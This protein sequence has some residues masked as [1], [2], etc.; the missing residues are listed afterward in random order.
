MKPTEKQWNWN[1]YR[2]YEKWCIVIGLA[3]YVPAI[4]A[5][6]VGV[7]ESFEVLQPACNPFLLAYILMAVGNGLSTIGYWCKNRKM[8]IVF[9]VIAI[10]CAIRLF[11]SL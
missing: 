10:I 4:V 9:L 7:L 2:T 1:E 6:I 11:I 5:L 8:A 3:C